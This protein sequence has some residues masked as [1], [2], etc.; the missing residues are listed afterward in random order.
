MDV[1]S[2]CSSSGGHLL[3]LKDALKAV[4]SVSVGIRRLRFFL[5]SSSPV[6]SSTYSLIEKK[7]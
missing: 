2:R 4:A 6:R 7:D 5:S 3:H 1:A